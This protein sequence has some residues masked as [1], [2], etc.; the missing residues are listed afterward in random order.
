MLR[1]LIGAGCICFLVGDAENVG[2]EN[3][4][5]KISNM[6]RRVDVMSK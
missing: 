2:A 5:M 1:T 4:G 3:V 6:V